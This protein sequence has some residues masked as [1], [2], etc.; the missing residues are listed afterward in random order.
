MEIIHRTKGPTTTICLHGRWICDDDLR[1]EM[2]DHVQRLIEI[3]RLDVVLDLSGVTFV[4]STVVGEISSMC[5]ALRRRGGQL[6]LLD[7][8]ARM[9]RLLCVSRLVSVIDVRRSDDSLAPLAR[10]CGEIIRGVDPETQVPIW[11]AA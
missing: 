10:P 7:P 5:L 1:T 11:S 2:R 8:T 9:V 4:D 3:G 6:T